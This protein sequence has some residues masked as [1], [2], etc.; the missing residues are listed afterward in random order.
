MGPEQSLQ[1]KEL[2]DEEERLIAKLRD[3][4]REF[5]VAMQRA[6]S[7]SERIAFFAAVLYYVG[8]EVQVMKGVSPGP[9]FADLGDMEMMIIRRVAAYVL[10]NYV[11]VP[12]GWTEAEILRTLDFMDEMADHAT[13]SK[14]ELTEGPTS[15]RDLG[16]A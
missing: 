14:A 5:A 10:D 2:N 9:S 6:E 16:G 7:E 8:Q 12:K 13:G 11:K 15:H 4:R 1:S 3:R